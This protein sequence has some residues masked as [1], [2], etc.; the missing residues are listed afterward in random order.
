MTDR[1]LEERRAALEEAFFARHNEA[2]LRALR[3]ADQKRTARGALAAASG[4][5]D[6]AVLDRLLALGVSAETLAALTLVPLV[7]VA[8][9]DGSLS[10]EERA[11][12]L[13]AAQ[14]AGLTHDDLGHRLFEQ[15]L[16]APPGPELAEAW[17]AYAR[18]LSAAR[19]PEE[20]A[21]LREAVLGQAR[22]VAEASGGFLGLGIGERISAAERRVLQELAAAFG[23]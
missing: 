8:W 17:K 10:V 22:A 7:L 23:P 19:A 12:V 11:A 13:A 2:L 5:G 1:F 18:A 4:I 6:E 16:D 21:A 20:R 3:E 9:A 15:W 14:K